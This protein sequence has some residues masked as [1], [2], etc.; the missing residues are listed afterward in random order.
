MDKKEVKLNLSEVKNN[1]SKIVSDLEMGITSK[2]ILTKN[3][4][5]AVVLEVY[6]EP[7][8]SVRGLWKGKAQVSDDFDEIPDEFSDYIK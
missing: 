8:T 2:V 7:K 3:G 5:P 1:L 6:S 4:K